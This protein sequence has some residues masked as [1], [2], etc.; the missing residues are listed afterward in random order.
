[1]ICLR[2]KRRYMVGVLLA[3]AILTIG[4]LFEWQNIPSVPCE[5][6]VVREKRIVEPDRYEDLRMERDNSRSVACELLQEEIGRASDDKMRLEKQNEL[7]EAEKNRQAETEIELILKA[8][9]YE[10]VL[11][12]C[13]RENVCVMVKTDALE[14]EEVAEIASIIARIA[15][16]SE[17][18]ILIRAKP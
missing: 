6:E 18:H 7:W 13:H 3:L 12:F 2:K 4:M 9:G 10:D 14:R 8:R 11:A 1:M 5:A 15:Q 16:V 17:E